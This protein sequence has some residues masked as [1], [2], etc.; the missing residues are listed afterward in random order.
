MAQPITPLAE[1]CAENARSI[2]EIPTDQLP[3]DEARAELVRRALAGCDVY[4]YRPAFSPEYVVWARQAHPSLEARFAPAEWAR[5]WRAGLQPVFPAQRG[6][7]G[8]A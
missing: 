1:E 7:G 6:E 8:A 2:R 5:Q 3:D 4:A